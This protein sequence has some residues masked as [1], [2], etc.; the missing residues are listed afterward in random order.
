MSF[1]GKYRRGYMKTYRELKREEAEARNAAYRARQA[2]AERE[3]YSGEYT[4][5]AD[6]G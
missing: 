3:R 1:T 4:H 2:E 5:E 6:R